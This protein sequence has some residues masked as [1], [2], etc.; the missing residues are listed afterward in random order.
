MSDFFDIEKNFDFLDL[1]DEPCN[2]SSGRSSS[3]E[4][5]SD[6]NEN[7]NSIFSMSASPLI[8][9]MMQYSYPQVSNFNEHATPGL[10][11]NACEFRP[12]NAMFFL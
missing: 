1:D 9:S 2:S 5:Q 12:T 6:N 10:K 7:E 8:D 11:V 3:D 4:R